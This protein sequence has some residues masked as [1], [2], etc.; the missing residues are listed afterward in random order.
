MRL[1][2]CP[3]TGPSA[4]DFDVPRAQ[5]AAANPDGDPKDQPGPGIVLPDGQSCL[6]LDGSVEVA[7]QSSRLWASNGA[8]APALLGFTSTWQNTVDFN[9]ETYNRT[10]IGDVTTRLELSAQTGQAEQVKAAWLQISNVVLGN[11]TSFYDV[12][13]ADEFTFH[14]FAPNQ[15]TNMIAG[16]FNMSD[17]TTLVVSLEDPLYRRATVSGYG[18]SGVPD[19]V[20]LSLIHI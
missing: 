13:T 19:L 7:S 14:A 6:F 2:A 12:W 5:A 10:A 9:V 8:F 3:W 4:D 20:A 16:V 15:S 1:R 18:P 11:R 17:A